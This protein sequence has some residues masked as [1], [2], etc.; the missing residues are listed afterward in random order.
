MR[1]ILALVALAAV[2][3][4]WWLL[5]GPDERT[6]L[7]AGSEERADAR[8]DEGPRLEGSSGP[9]PL[10]AGARAGRCTLLG[11]VTRAG[12]PAASAV[13][14]RRLGEVELANYEERRRMTSLAAEFQVPGEVRPDRTTQSDE[15]GAFETSGLAPGLH[16][17][18]ARAADGTLAWANVLLTAE[19]ARVE[20]A[21]ELA[22]ADV[23]L[24]GSVRYEDGRPF[25]GSL[26]V[27]SY[28][29]PPVGARRSRVGDESTRIAAVEEDGTF[30]VTG[31][32][33]G[34]ATA[35]AVERD[36][37]L[38][39]TFLVV[40]P[41]KAPLALVVPVGKE[42]LAGRVLAAEGDQ[43]VA[44]ATVVVTWNGPGS[45]SVRRLLATDAEG[46]FATEFG[47]DGRWTLS[48]WGNA[49]GKGYRATGEAQTGGTLDLTLQLQ[50]D[51]PPM[52]MPVPVAR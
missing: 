20:I 44:G 16:H 39:T 8:R 26:L 30:R 2:G 23:V 15:Q 32:Q 41:T 17:V 7:A 46:R 51:S 28:G 36:G 13:E 38:V 48:A 18:L 3:G 52:P 40:L 19:G 42:R 14:I 27:L 37:T 4:A 21:L 47:P 11:R 25:V 35:R 22:L 34:N 10:T 12:R 6:N 50:G 33:A 9:A 29:A 43:P 49:E 45:T 1:W 31:L 24:E 5:R